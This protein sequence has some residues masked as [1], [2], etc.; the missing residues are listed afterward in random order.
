MGWWED[1]TRGFREGIDAGQLA[2][3]VINP[4][5]AVAR[6]ATGS[7]NLEILANPTAAA[8]GEALTSAAGMGRSGVAGGGYANTTGTLTPAQQAA[9]READMAYGRNIWSS[10][11]GS[12]PEYAAIMN[13]Y[14]DMS[15][16]LNAQE[17]QAARE[18]MARG[19]QGAASSA[20]RS[21]Y[22][23]QAKSGI[24]GGMAGA[25]AA[26]VGRQIASDRTA[27]EQKLLLDNYALRRQGLQDY[28]GAVNRDISGELGTGIGYAG[29]GVSDRTA[30]QQ[31]AIAQ[32][33]AAANNRQSGGLMSWIFG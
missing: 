29:L 32:A 13:R 15:Q 25:Q 33:M 6:Q 10:L 31:Q 27:A 30:A 14:K 12:R 11:V 9:A 24:R 17:M 4:V 2:R 5:G 3:D 18:Q 23:N 22:S 8:S 21:L 20:M 7:R 19:Q 16:G 1:A 28:S 26:R